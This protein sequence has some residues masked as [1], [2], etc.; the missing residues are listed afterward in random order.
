M[1]IDDERD[2]R[3]RRR[4]YELWEK[5]GKRDGD[6][7]RHWHEAAR[8]IDDGTRPGGPGP[9]GHGE[10]GLASDLQPGRTKPNGG[11]GRGAGSMGS[12]GDNKA[13]TPPR[14]AGAA[15]KQPKG[16]GS[17]TAGE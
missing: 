14:G 8:E 6:S 7:E 13:K 15:T 5:E 9:D 17:K 16:V 12:K 4:A 10:S 11:P 2:E 3:I 1:T